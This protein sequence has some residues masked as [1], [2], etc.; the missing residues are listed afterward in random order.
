M[1]DLEPIWDGESGP[2][3]PL[4]L[5]DGGAV[6]DGNT[7]V[8][9]IDV[10]DADG[11]FIAKRAGLPVSPKSG[12]IVNLSFLGRETDWDGLGRDLILRPKVYAA[13]SPLGAPA[14]N[15]LLTSSFDTDGDANGIADNWALVGAKTATW[16][17]NVDSPWPPVIFG[18]S[19]LVQ[20]AT[21]V[22]PDYIQQ[23]MAVTLVPGDRISFGVWHR[24]DGVGGVSADTHAMFYFPGAQA[25]Q[26]TRF[27]VG[28]NDW[29]FS[30]GMYIVTTNETAMTL[31]LAARRWRTSTTTLS[32]SKGSGECSRA[33]R[34]GSRY[35]RGSAQPSPRIKSRA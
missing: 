6:V 29:Y 16:A 1:K 26:F 9:E 15:L 25:A 4:A 33:R 22:E 13:V 11:T 19:Q 20:H 10:Y 24:S 31:G 2:I 8:V 28:T 14:A 27:S 30:T 7:V 17:M 12:G 21:T 5:K 18:S 34:T 3:Y 23:A 35:G 32:R